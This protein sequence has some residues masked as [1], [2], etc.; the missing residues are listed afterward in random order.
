MRFFRSAWFRTLIL[1][2]CLIPLVWLGVDYFS[3]R[4]EPNPAQTLEV[5]T[6]RIAIS[7]LVVSLS[8]SPLASLLNRPAILRA[9]RTLG[10]VTFFYV[11]LHVLVLAGFDYGFDLPVLVDSYQGKP[12]IW[13][14]LLTGLILAALALTSFDW[15]KQKLGIWWGRLHRLIYLAAILDLTHYFLA[16]KGNLFSLSGNLARP[17]FFCAVIIL[18]LA[19]RVVQRARAT[20]TS[21]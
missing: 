6:G 4:M 21:R 11:L 1:A 12:F 10:L 5:R 17:L 18:L 16:V 13:F 15:W 8:V 2:G 9:R 7:L 3:G 14:G 19:L 20:A